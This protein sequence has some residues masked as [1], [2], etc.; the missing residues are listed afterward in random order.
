MGGDSANAGRGTRHV[1]STKVGVNFVEE[2]NKI[3]GNSIPAFGRSFPVSVST[4]A[5]RSLFSV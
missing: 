4:P 1:M 5:V 2:T 3:F